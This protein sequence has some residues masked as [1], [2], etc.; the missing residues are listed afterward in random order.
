MKAL[1]KRRPLQKENDMSR[2]N[3]FKISELQFTCEEK[4]A[5]HE[6]KG[7]HGLPEIKSRIF[8]LIMIKI[9]I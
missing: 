7:S 3:D 2:F 4:E 8:N 9:L 5:K 6:R 1:L